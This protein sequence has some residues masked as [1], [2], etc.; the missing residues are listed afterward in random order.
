M[1]RKTILVAVA[2]PQALADIASALGDGWDATLVSNEADA[3]AQLE[4][5]S[6]DALLAD[7]NLGST[8][9]SELL[10]QA[11]QKRPETVRFLLAHEAD[12]AL[13]AA[14]VSGPHEILPKPVEPDSLKSRIESGVSLP[15]ENPIPNEPEPSADSAP[16]VVP[17][18]YGELLK[19]IESPGV[20]NN[21]VGQIIAQDAE[22]TAEVLKLAKSTSQR[23]SRKLTYPAEAVEWLG[24]ETVK[25]L[26]MA[27]RFLTEH[28][29][30]KPGYLSL[31][32]LW[33]HSTNVAQLAWD[34]V[35]FET[36]DRTLAAEALVAGLLH[37]LGKVVLASNFDDLYSRVHSLA[38]KHPVALWEIEKEMFGANHG[39][40]GACLVGMWNLPDPIVQAVALHH[41]PPL[42]EYRQL[43]ALAAVHIANVLEHQILSSEEFQVSPVI[44][45]PFL[46]EIGLLQRLPVWRAVLANRRAASTDQELPPT[47]TNHTRSANP[48]FSSALPIESED[49]Q[50]PP[51]AA[52]MTTT[53]GQSEC[54]AGMT[55]VS[56]SFRPHTWVYACVAVAA[57]GLLSLWLGTRPQ[58]DVHALTIEPTPIQPLTAT[59][60][61]AASEPFA[62]DPTEATPV[63]INPEQPSTLDPVAT[64]DPVNAKPETVA[65]VADSLPA[66]GTNNPAPTLMTEGN[67]HVAPV[68]FRLNGVLYAV[69]RP[70]AIVNGQTVYT[71][72]KVSG[73]KVVA[74]DR[75][76]VI[77]ETNGRN[78]LLS[79]PQSR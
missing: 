24:L 23:L 52:T 66:N 6:F 73:A 16:V 14:Y 33:Q 51:A 43:T 75:T 20:T 55:A 49:E 44:S 37:D 34:L 10:N 58:M 79:L 12:L 48:V 69:T 5:R 74:I 57:I 38:R 63:T 22:L 53:M 42:G 68:D 2:D 59:P 70:A 9:A 32:K 56:S 39:E 60:P 67:A 65:N 46:N 40:I 18:V 35:L 3:L 15:E 41:E 8:D 62:A 13:V 50:M 11:L 72:D 78:I 77:L 25:A 71:G 61:V 76:S 45:M 28:G 64:P 19:A 54:E 47:E 1:S 31:E 29:Q 4:L 21:Q 27:R 30:L 17:A 36:N 26:V 7:F